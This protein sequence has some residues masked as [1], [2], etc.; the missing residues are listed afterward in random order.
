M[1]RLW[2][3]ICFVLLMGGL[4][5]PAGASA[6]LLLSSH[7]R[8]DPNVGANF[9]G[10]G[11]STHYGLTDSGGE[12]VVGAGAS[13]SYKLG[14]GY[15]RQ[16][17]QSIELTVLPSGTYA[18]WPMDTGTGTAAYDMSTNSDDGTLQAS[19]SW[20]GGIVGNGISLNGSSQYITTAKSISGP[21]TFS[22]EIWFKTAPGYGNGG[23]LMGF[24][25]SASGSSTNL[26]RIIYMRNDGKI[27]FG[28]KPSSIKTVTSG[29]GY[30]D[31]SWHHVVGTLGSHG[32]LLYVDGLLE[33]SDPTTTTAG[34][35]SGNWRMGFDNLTGWPSAPTSNYMAATIDEARVYSREISAK[36]VTND[37]VAGQNA[38]HNAF[39]LP[40]I[41]PGISQSDSVD[42]VVRTNAPS[43]DLSMQAPTPLTHTDTTTVFPDI[44]PGDI[45]TPVA[46]TEGTTKGFG[47]TLTAGFGLDAKWGTGPNYKYA[48]VPSSDTVFHSRPGTSPSDGAPEITTIQYR[49][50]AAPVQKQGTYSTVIIYTATLK[51]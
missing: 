45:T 35:Y 28:V 15:V 16:L 9:G 47:F 5:L 38:L 50:D 21:S 46:W 37:F 22:T 48:K 40:D 36:E 39:T 19:P 17:P 10:T 18:Y 23:E 31:G 8:L 43:Y 51:P 3:K 26:D 44:S 11:G 24:G 34:S 49:A 12:A 4:V 13:Q 14:Q 29:S 42:A 41:T 30:N 20:A 32:L 25:D 6:D 33:G 27:T 1:L 7:F 2:R